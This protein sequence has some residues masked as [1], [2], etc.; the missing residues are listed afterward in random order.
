VGR[1]A[2]ITNQIREKRLL[3][4]P[5]LE[6]GGVPWWPRDILLH[7]H[8][9]VP[10]HHMVVA[11]VLRLTHEYSP[12]SPNRQAPTGLRRRGRGLVS[13]LWGF[14]PLSKKWRAT[15]GMREAPTQRALVAAESEEEMRCES[16]TGPLHNGPQCR[17]EAKWRRDIGI[18][19]LAPPHVCDEHKEDFISH[20]DRASGKWVP[21][22]W[23]P[24]ERQGGLLK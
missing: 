21:G 6:Q 9:P 19:P 8:H 13:A 12:T 23:E 16:G 7:V 15:N 10:R 20:F 3:G 11:C 14:R 17:R 22:V 1:E 2:E 24:L 4:W 5:I 18:G